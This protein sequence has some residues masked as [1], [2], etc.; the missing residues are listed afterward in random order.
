MNLI[1]GGKKK[2]KGGGQEHTFHEVQLP[3]A[4]FVE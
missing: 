1:E 2:T 3:H 4:L